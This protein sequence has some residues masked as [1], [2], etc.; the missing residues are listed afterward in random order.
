M[1]TLEKRISNFT[2]RLCSEVERL[3]AAAERKR[4]L[5]AS[6]SS[7]IKEALYVIKTESI[8]KKKCRKCDSDRT[9]TYISPAGREVREDCD[10]KEKILIRKPSM[11]LLNRIEEEDDEVVV[12]F[13]DEYLNTITIPY[14]SMIFDRRDVRTSPESIFYKDFKECERWCVMLNMDKW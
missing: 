6:I 4:V 8:K 10:Y 7:N 1:T 14:N 13:I 2:E 12:Y 11:L 3:L 9:I 5:A